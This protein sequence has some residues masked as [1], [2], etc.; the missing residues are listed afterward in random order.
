[1]GEQLVL[2]GVIDAASWVDINAVGFDTT[3]DGIKGE[4]GISNHNASL[5]GT[6]FTRV[7]TAWRAMLWIISSTVVQQSARIHTLYFSAAFEIAVWVTQFW[8]MKPGVQVSTSTV[9][10]TSWVR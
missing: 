5:D 7:D 4:W 1:M 3:K 8:V 2:T 9:S 10:R 6:N